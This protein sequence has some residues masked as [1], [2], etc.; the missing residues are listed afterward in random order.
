MQSKSA[1]ATLLYVIFKKV[2]MQ[3]RKCKYARNKSMQEI[4]VC[5]KCKY[6]SIH[7]V[8]VKLSF[9]HIAG[10]LQL[11][12]QALNPKTSFMKVVKHDMLLM[13]V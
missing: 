4:L 9:A 1:T 2:S 8:K 5:K 11:V 7:N 12:N 10:A 6:K 13:D 3:V